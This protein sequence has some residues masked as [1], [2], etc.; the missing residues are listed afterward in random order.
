MD[1]CRAVTICNH[2]AYI[3]P[4]E[5]EQ[6]DTLPLCSKCHRVKKCVL[7]VGDFVLCFHIFCAFLLMI[8]LFKTPPEYSANVLSNVPQGRRL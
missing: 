5:V 3:V 4:A 1:V 8:L 6:S 2:S 7:F